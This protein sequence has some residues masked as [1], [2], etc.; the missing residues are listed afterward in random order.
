MRNPLCGARNNLTG[1]RIT[2]LESHDLFDAMKTLLVLFIALLPLQAQEIQLTLNCQI[3]RAHDFKTRQAGPSS[4]SFSAIV[5]MSNSQD[6]TIEVTTGFCFNYVGSL[7]EQ[8]VIGE[9]KRTVGNSK[10]WA[11]LT[12]NRLNGEFEQVFTSSGGSAEIEYL[13]GHCT[14][15]KKL[16]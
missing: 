16:F 5:H 12:I 11:Y 10:Y 13:E 7:S 1:V 3:E 8:E 2:D 4:G 14:P 9:C 6:A 15:G